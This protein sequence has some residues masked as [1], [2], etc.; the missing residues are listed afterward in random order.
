M[1]FRDLGFRA[2]MKLTVSISDVNDGT[3]RIKTVASN[4]LTLDEADMIMP[5]MDD[6]RVSLEAVTEFSFNDVPV[7]DTITSTTIDF[8]QEGFRPGMRIRVSGTNDNDGIYLV[9]DVEAKKLT[10]VEGDVLPGGETNVSD[11]RLQGFPTFRGREFNA[12]VYGGRN[13]DGTSN[14]GVIYASFADQIFVR[15]GFRDARGRRAA[16]YSAQIPS[17]TVVADIVVDVNNWMRAIVRQA[18]AHGRWRI[19]G[20][21]RRNPGARRPAR[22]IVASDAVVVGPDRQSGTRTRPPGAGHIAWPRP[23]RSGSASM[24]AGSSL[25][26]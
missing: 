1:N 17:N 5:D 14:P 21:G 2:G 13:P 9:E 19:V 20:T 25:I 15:P 23:A 22:R 4:A 3:Y 10:L 6:D 24:T 16:F 18:D 7:A 8:V 11:V 26:H 12:L